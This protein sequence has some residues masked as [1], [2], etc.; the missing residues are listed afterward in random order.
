MKLA[1]FAISLGVVASGLV[2]RPTYAATPTA[3]FGVTA[4]VPATCVVSVSAT[5]H[6]LNSPVGKKGISDISITCSHSTPYTVGVSGG[7]G[8]ETHVIVPR[9]TGDGS[10]NAVAGL[11]DRSLRMF[12]DHDEIPAGQYVGSKTSVGFI[13]V[14]V[15][16]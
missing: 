11:G 2:S 4:T 13:T 10:A 1:L 12:A 3:S 7:V 9:M 5:A 6:D 8:A 16:Y 15:T 14:T